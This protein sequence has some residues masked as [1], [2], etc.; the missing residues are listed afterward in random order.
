MGRY[1]GF[2]R[3]AALAGLLLFAAAPAS[4]A[5]SPAAHCQRVGTDDTTRPIPA[6]LVPEA[7]RLFGLAKAPADWVRQSTLYRCARHRVLLCNLG[8][9]LACG[10]AD[11]RRQLPAADRWC[12]AH[13][14]SAFIPMAVTGHDTVFDWR[15]A[16]A[17]AAIA[18][19]VYRVDGQGFVAAMWKPVAAAP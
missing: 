18:K 4:H 12:A 8:A 3:L 9:N 1:R 13:R 17:K 7:V 16:G 10:K 15:C 6:A 14:G 5:A 11:T 19:Q 2:H